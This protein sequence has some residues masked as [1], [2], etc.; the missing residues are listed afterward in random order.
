MFRSVCLILSLLSAAVLDAQSP[1]ALAVDANAARHPISPLIYGIN[2]WTDSG[3]S[4]LMHI[5]VRRWGG[6]NA[7]SYNWQLDLKNNDD[8]WYFTTYLLGDGVTSTFD[9][10]HERNLETGTASLGTVPILDWTPKAPPGPLAVNQVLSCSFAVAKYGA[11]QKTDPYDSACGNGL[12]AAGSYIVND[13]NDVYEPITPAFAGQWVQY[14]MSKYGPA[15]LGGVQMWSLDNEPEWWDGVHEDMYH[16]I[17]SYDDMLARDTATA[18]AV[19]AADPTAL[20]TGPVPSGWWGMN[21][22]KKDMNSGWSTPPYCYYDNP[23][24]QN[25]HGG[26]PWVVYYLQQMQAFE[27]ANGYRLLDY[28]DVHGY[29]TPPTIGFDTDYSV[30]NTQLRMT[31]T[32][33]LWDT[34]YIVPGFTN[35][36]GT[37]NCQ[38]YY[39]AAGTPVAPALV[40]TMHS[41]V[42]ANYPGTKTAITEYNWGA[43]E[44][45]T[46]AVAQADI[47]GIFG[48]EQ[49]DMATMWPDGNFAVGVP[50]AFAFQIFLNYDGNGNQFGETSISA[51]TGNPDTLDI[52]AAQRSDMA[53]TILVLNKTSAAITDSVSIANF[54]PAGTLQT[55]QYSSANLNAI[56]LG[57]A[58][59]SGNSVSATF[60]AYSMTLFVIPQSQSAMTVPKPIVNWVKNAASWN[61]SAIAPGE[62]VA[63]QG[64]S[65]GPSQPVFASSASQ[66]GTSLGGVSVLFNGIPGAMI[67]TTPISGDTQQLAVV[68]PYEIAANPAT[69]SVNVQVEVQGNSSDP[70]PMPVTTA[71]PGLFTNDY[72]GLGQAAAL[73]QDTVN[74]QTVLTRNGPLNASA[75]PPTQPATRGSY[76]LLYATGEGQTSPPGVDGRIAATIFPSP[77]LSCSVSIG[78]IAVTPASC[79]ATPNSTA[80]ELQVK[81]QVPIGVTPGNNVP[82]QVTIGNVTSPAGVTIAVQ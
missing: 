60:P 10:F 64:T 51:T 54:A 39:N 30:T 76:I 15:D 65:V 28:L 24:D 18:Q 33:A 70:I 71:L 25:A 50:G 19:K 75:N 61:A 42:N 26:L 12:T 11:Q 16:S 58:A 7:T 3:M 81:A 21:F 79:G 49:L 23:I 41:W 5:G 34:N 53:L 72:S 2:E 57:T 4:A 20:V 31:S 9:M 37:S 27:N 77:V 47:L 8:D 74:G 69:T 78:G 40:P 14:I 59:I 1:P 29:I 63:I 36:D 66:L 46:G 62:V 35:A 82:V 56:V 13:P 52:F 80:G 45:I 55:F 44:D 32:R 67:Y 17:A 68:V 48:R 73:N 38:G 6:D 22:S 43:L